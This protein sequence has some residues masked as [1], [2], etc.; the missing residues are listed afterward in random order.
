MD[1]WELLKEILEICKE[2]GFVYVCIYSRCFWK[3]NVIFDIIF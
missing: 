1:C 3:Y 2:Q